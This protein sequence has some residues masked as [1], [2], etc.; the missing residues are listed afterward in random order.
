MELMQ[1]QLRCPS[2]DGLMDP[3]ERRRG[4]LL[5]DLFDFDW[6]AGRL[7]IRRGQPS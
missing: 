1:R 2:C 6:R 3:V 5:G 7:G 4:G